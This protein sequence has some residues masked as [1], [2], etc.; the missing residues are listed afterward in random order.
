MDVNPLF[1]VEIFLRVY[2]IFSVNEHESIIE[3][4][5]NTTTRFLQRHD[6]TIIDLDSFLGNELLS[7]F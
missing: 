6:L 1:V 2:F 7:I 3:V 4:A 5:Y